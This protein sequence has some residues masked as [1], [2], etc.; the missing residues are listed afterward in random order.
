MIN[1][2][3]SLGIPVRY[4]VVCFSLLFV[5][6]IFANKYKNEKRKRI[7]A[8][9]KLEKIVREREEEILYDLRTRNENNIP[10]DREWVARGD[11]PAYRNIPKEWRATTND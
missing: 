10:D 3:I 8:E 2:A 7:E 9:E 1:E 11:M 4:I 6:S 5:I